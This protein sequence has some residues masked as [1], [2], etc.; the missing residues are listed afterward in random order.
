MLGIHSS[1]LDVDT[2]WEKLDKLTAW[3]MTNVKSNRN[4]I[5]GSTKG[6]KNSPFCHADGHLS[7][8][9]NAE[10]EPKFQTFQGRF[11]LRGVI[12]KDDSGAYSVSY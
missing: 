2:E 6:A 9:K 11:V 8:Q 7:S 4:V 5:S 12:V 10:L 3:Q 1:E